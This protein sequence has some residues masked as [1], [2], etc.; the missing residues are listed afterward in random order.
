MKLLSIRP[1][2]GKDMH[3]VHVASIAYENEEGKKKIVPV[4]SRRPVK[5]EADLSG[6]VSGVEAIVLDSNKRLLVAKEFRLAVN[7]WVYGLPTGMPEKSESYSDAA[8]RE[9]SEE[10]GV[11]CHAVKAFPPAYINPAESNEMLVTV[12]CEA[13]DCTITGSDSANEE[14]EASFYS[15]E[16]LK[17]LASDSSNAFSLS[18]LKMIGGKNNE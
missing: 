8:C 16:E 1:E 6:Y 2:G 5:K 17:A 12:V 11:K 13:D 14:V 3:S 4:F 15:V 18:L 10:T 9:V 7:R